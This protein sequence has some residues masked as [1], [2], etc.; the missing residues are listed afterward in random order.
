MASGLAHE[1]NQPLCA[2]ANYAD[3]CQQMMR[4]EAVDYAKLTDATE[5]IAKQTER[6]GEIIRRLKDLVRKREPR[7]STVNIN[8][9]VRE[10]IEIEQ[11]EANQGGIAIQTK[12]AE[13]VS[14]ILA[15]KIQV[16]QVVLNLVRNAF[17]AMADSPAGR[18]KLTIQTSA[19][20][21]DAIEVAVRDTGKGLSAE[22]SEQIFDSFFSTKA[23][24]LGIGLSL[25]R[26]IIEAHGGRLWAEPNPDCGAT[27]LFTLPLKG[28]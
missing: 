19:A 4:K 24:G 28:A 26:S 27:F 18:R 22:N 9:I 16:E 10:V 23:D 13:D 25:S 3:G 11:T 15:D 8:D 21:S 17:E 14:L 6:A 20:G 5:Q 1:L 12:L 7:Q 2:I